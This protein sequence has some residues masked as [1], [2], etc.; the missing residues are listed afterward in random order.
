MDY[1]FLLE[2]INKIEEI[3]QQQSIAIAMLQ[4]YI[5]ATKEK[6][7]N[8]K[9]SSSKKESP[10]VIKI[11]V[12]KGSKGSVMVTTGE[13]LRKYNGKTVRKRTD[14]RY[15]LRYY[16]GKKYHSVYGKTQNECIEKYRNTLKL[17]KNDKKTYKE[18]T[19]GD[20]LNQWL[21]LYKQNK[22]AK[23]TFDQMQRYLKEV[24]MLYQYKLKK[25]SP[26]LLQEFLNIL[27]LDCKKN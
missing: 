23:S 24:Q 19:L 17:N 25:I 5:L 4:G 27:Y 10:T 26:I 6:D 18:I 7:D 13:E 3:Q 14:G 20:W 21:R 9:A 1:E 22:V 12:P 15:E 2:G 8:A 16:D 11:D